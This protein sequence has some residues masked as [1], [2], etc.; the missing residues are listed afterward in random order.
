[1]VVRRSRV[2][3]PSAARYRNP[4]KAQGIPVFFCFYFLRW[5]WGDAVNLPYKILSG[6]YFSHHTEIWSK[7]LYVFLCI[8]TVKIIPV[9]QSGIILHQK[10]EYK[11]M[12]G[13]NYGD[14]RPVYKVDFPLVFLSTMYLII[15]SRTSFRCPLRVLCR[16]SRGHGHV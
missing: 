14:I 13:K 2:R 4:L 7:I 1:M 10:N 3:F 5:K 15:W 6:F 12:K 9:H 11:H 8:I 16:G